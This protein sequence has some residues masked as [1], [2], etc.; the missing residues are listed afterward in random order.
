[1]ISLLE[2]GLPPLGGR[3]FFRLVDKAKVTS[4]PGNYLPQ[5]IKIQLRSDRIR[6]WRLK[7]YRLR[8]EPAKQ[9][10]RI[11]IVLPQPKIIA[12]F[13]FVF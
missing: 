5:Q 9:T 4:P 2:S 13:E 1:M 8:N 7:F 6:L 12:I 11:G 3:L 10:G